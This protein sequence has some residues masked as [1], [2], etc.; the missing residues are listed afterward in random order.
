M[1][2]KPVEGGLE[3]VKAV[4]GSLEMLL[5]A[6]LNQAVEGGVES[7]VKAVGGGLETL[8]ILALNK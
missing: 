3:I 4:E 2:P 8:L 1:S 5:M 6:A 7:I